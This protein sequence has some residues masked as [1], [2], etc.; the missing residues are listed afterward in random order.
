M[1]RSL[2]HFADGWWRWQA[3][4]LVQVAA[5]ILFLLVVDACIRR[6]AW[7]RLR[8]ALW[9]LV[10]VKLVLP[11]GL[12]SPV[13]LIGHFWPR[14]ES[15]EAQALAAPPAKPAAA[16]VPTPSVAPTISPATASPVAAT[17]V[18]A[19]RTPVSWKVWPLALWALGVLVLAGWLVSRLRRFRRDLALAVSDQPP[20]EWLERVLQEVAAQLKLRRVPRVQISHATASPA[21]FGL[22]RPVVLL[23]ASE[24]HTLSEAEGRH[25]LL[26]ELA[27]VKRGDLVLHALHI[28]LLIL[29]WFNPLLWVVRRF[30]QNLREL[31]CDATVANA[32]R[33]DVPAYRDT[34][35]N[36]ARRLLAQTPPTGLGLLGWFENS[37]WLGIRLRWLQRNTWKRRWLQISATL[38]LV[39]TI[40]GCVLPMGRRALAKNTEEYPL[41]TREAQQILARYRAYRE[42]APKRYIL[43]Q[44]TDRGL[45]LL[46]RDGNRARSAYY[47]FG[48]RGNG[49]NNVTDEA[50][51]EDRE[52]AGTTLA[53][54]VAWSADKIPI[55]LRM[56]DG[57]F[58][59]SCESDGFGALVGT[60]RQKLTDPKEILSFVMNNHSLRRLCWPDPTFQKEDFRV[61]VV[62]D[63]PYAR[64]HGLVPLEFEL[65][66]GHSNT[67][68]LGITLPYVYR[69]YLDPKKDYICVR[70][71]E[72]RSGHIHEITGLERT[73]GGGFLPTQLTDFGFSM[74]REPSSNWEPIVTEILCDLDPSFPAGIFDMDALEST[75]GPLRP[76]T[77]VYPAG[78]DYNLRAQAQVNGT[79]VAGD[80]GEPIANALVRIAMPATDMRNI[81]EGNESGSK[82]W[83]TR[84]DAKGH[85]TVRFPAKKGSFAID[86]FS[87]GFR[88]VAGTYTSGGDF[89][90]YRVP[91]NKGQ[92]REVNIRLRR[93]KYVAGTV[94]DQAGKPKAGVRVSGRVVDGG[95]TAFI[96]ST[97]TD[98]KGHFELFDFFLQP[99]H[100]SERAQLVF[101]HP[102][103]ERCVVE[104][105][106]KMTDQALA[107]LTVTMRP[108]LA[109]VGTVLGADG[110]PCAATTVFA[111]TE[112]GLC[113]RKATTDDDGRF[114]LPGLAPGKIILHTHGKRLRENCRQPVDLVDHD[115]TVTLRQQLQPLP[116]GLKTTEFLGSRVAD[117]TPELQQAYDLAVPF[118]IVVIDPGKEHQRLGIE[119]LKEGCHVWYAGGGKVRSV[120]EAAQRILGTANP[121]PGTV[122][123]INP[124]TVVVG[125][126]WGKRTEHKLTL[127]AADIAALVARTA[128]PVRFGDP[129]QLNAEQDGLKIWAI[130]FRK[131]DETA[132]AE[133]TATYPSHPKASWQIH[134]ALLDDA[135]N[136]LARATESVENSGIVLGLPLRQEKGLVLA[137]PLDKTEKATQFTLTIEYRPAAG[138][139]PSSLPA[140]RAKTGAGGSLG[141]IRTLAGTMTW[142]VDEDILAFGKEKTDLWWEQVDETNRFLTPQNGAQLAILPGA[143]FEQVTA[144]QARALKLSTAKLSASDEGSVLPPGTIVVFRTNRNR[145]GVL[146]IVRYRRLHDLSF[147]E[148]EYIRKDPKRPISEMPDRPRQ[149]LTMRW[150]FLD[151]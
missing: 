136:Q 150:R 88:T 62:P 92:V 95:T 57:T 116:E 130:T 126:G 84:S 103:A 6:W 79:I 146:E 55:Y 114:R 53:S 120:N 106:Y 108:G 149:H 111:C 30:F 14:E 132:V 48:V 128:M 100:P 26:H 74:A 99:R 44:R 59:R 15:K 35:L 113:L 73:E 138:T 41:A 124:V 4:M 43:A 31:C 37:R 32:L 117:V 9:L 142:D 98:S 129:V 71:Q 125:R 67:T 81:R 20:P 105:L 102:E 51:A 139:S 133:F 58:F 145:L 69:R 68:Y 112:K 137:F 77:V 123:T 80:T 65:K 63:D 94:V 46:F 3:D 140:G 24:T 135:G 12:T 18:H 8:H 49:R 104:G 119:D 7:P 50:R 127:S 118:G 29:Y 61:R 134:L 78:T 75:Y 10:L 86:V 89:D 2:N 143:A 91:I 56:C 64:E 42:Q 90:L 97:R 45:N 144:E 131:Q 70:R 72:R 83:D 23:P 36:T 148:A 82:L 38:V 107:S 54:L 122:R 13:S 5:L 22:F 96:A 93:A 66:P 141:K 52:Q 110:A 47:Q 16:T 27:H 25:I 76:K 40:A 115:Q 151:E 109:I 39:L 87:P 85:F 121:F 17:T 101:T 60:Q 21:V 19:P 1:I 34:L 33:Q 28:V 147:P 11:P